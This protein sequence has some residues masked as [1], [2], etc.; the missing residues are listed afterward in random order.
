MPCQALI[1]FFRIGGPD[2]LQWVEADLPPPAAGEVQVR[3]RAVGVNFIDTYHH[4]GLYPVPLLPAWARR[5]P[6]SSR[7]WARVSPN[8]PRATGS[9]TRAAR[10][11][12]C[13]APQHRRRRCW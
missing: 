2:V 13:R 7:R 1:H 6:A 10:R 11:G 8:S 4:S 5:R 9:P 3:H 12:Y